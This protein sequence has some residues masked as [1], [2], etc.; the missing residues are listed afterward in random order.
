[1]VKAGW[2]LCLT[3]KSRESRVHTVAVLSETQVWLIHANV[4]STS[5]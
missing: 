3:C 2:G 5:Q 4:I 1:M